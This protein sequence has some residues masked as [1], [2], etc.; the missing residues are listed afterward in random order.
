MREVKEAENIGGE[1]DGL[2]TAVAVGDVAFD[3]DE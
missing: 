1:I 2:G 3:V